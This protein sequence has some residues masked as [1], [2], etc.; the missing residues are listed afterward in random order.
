[1][2]PR[3]LEVATSALLDDLATNRDGVYSAFN[4]H[5]DAVLVFARRK[6]A[7]S[8][9]A[10]LKRQKELLD[11]ILARKQELCRSNGCP[12]ASECL[13]GKNAVTV[14]GQGDPRDNCAPRPLV[15][16]SILH[17]PAG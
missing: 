14:G 7:E 11:R 6:N 10:S 16:R 13:R 4:E 12:P 15:P 1:V 9:L 8:Y 3:S 17:L 5:V 2:E